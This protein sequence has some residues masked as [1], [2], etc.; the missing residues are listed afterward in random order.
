MWKAIGPSK[1]LDENTRKYI[2]D[3]YRKYEATIGSAKPVKAKV[4]SLLEFNEETNNLVLR[5]P[6]NNGREN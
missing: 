3:L 4:N 6:V 2:R 5:M 1:L